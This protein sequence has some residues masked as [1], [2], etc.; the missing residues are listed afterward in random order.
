M[1][2]WVNTGP[3]YLSGL[4][5]LGERNPVNRN[6]DRRD[7]WGMDDR[8]H[9]RR[10]RRNH[11]LAAIMSLVRGI[12]GHVVAALHRLLILGHG[13]AVGELQKE[14]DADSHNERCDLPKHQQVPLPK[15]LL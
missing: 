4:F 6:R 1:L 8:Q 15:Y 10:L 14:H 9:A 11:V 7:E 13:V 5:H 2:W 12:A 3:S